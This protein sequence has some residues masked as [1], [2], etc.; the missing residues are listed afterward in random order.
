M[1]MRRASIV[2]HIHD[3]ASLDHHLMPNNIAFNVKVAPGPNDSQ[4]DAVGH[5]TG[6]A[7]TFFQ[8]NGMQMQFNVVSTETLRDAMRNPELYP[9]LMVRISGYNAYFNDLNDDMK[10]E[11]IER[12]EHRLG[13]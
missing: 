8:E 2:E 6:Y 11:L 1:A 10:R 7:R 9:T 5:M 12:A 13:A 3:V 4:S